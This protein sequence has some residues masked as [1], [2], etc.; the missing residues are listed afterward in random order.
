M[1]SPALILDVRGLSVSFRGGN[2]VQAVENVDLSVWEGDHLCIVGE[3]GSGKSIL[4][5]A[6]L[7]LLSGDAQVTG[8]VL[9]RGESL[10]RMPQKRLDEVRGGLISYI[11]QGSGNGMNPLLKVGFQVGEPLMAHCGLKRRD[12][13]RR[14]VDLLRRFHLQREEAVARQYPF[15]LSGGMRQRA[16]IAMGVAADAEALLADEPTKGLDERRVRLVEESFRS[17]R[18][19]T[20]VC[21][22]HDLNFARS[23]AARV[24]VMYA[25]NLVEI[26]DKEAFYRE[27][28]H[29]Y[30]RD[31]LM[32]MPE[33]G[34]RF[35]PGF[36]PSHDEYALQGC[37][38]CARCG[39]RSEQCKNI[40]PMVDVDGRRVRCWKYA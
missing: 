3:T 30:S 5:L 15:A 25:A 11:P 14:S 19:Q 20:I 33:N 38:Y 8:D 12:A 40:P 21:V 13:Q 32:A 28:L 1:E 29:P 4:L 31:M 36:A 39:D 2:H 6:M 34:L 24:G 7:R 26:A 22:T 27:P 37:K 35:N 23:V 18:K 16:M 17:L 10:F 9:Y